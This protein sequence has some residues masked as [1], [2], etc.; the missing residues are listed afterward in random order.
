MM[1]SNFEM[2]QLL[3]IILINIFLLKFFRNISEFI[4]LF[5]YPYEKRKIHKIKVASIGGFLVVF[6]LF[7]YLFLSIFFKSN[8]E[9]NTSILLFGIVFFFLG[10][11]DDKSNLN[12]IIRLA[13]YIIISF[14]LIETNENILVKE[15]KFS[16]FDSVISLGSYS[17]IFTIFCI[18]IFLNAFNMF[19]GINLQSSIYSIFIFSIFAIKNYYLNLS[20][21]IIISLLFFLVLNYKNK[22][23]LGNNGSLFL[24]FLISFIFIESS[25]THLFYS[26]EILL[27]M[28]IPGLDLIR[29]FIERIKKKQNPFSADSNHIHHLLISKFNLIQTNLIIFALIFIPY[30]I[31]LLIG[32]FFLLTILHSFIYLILIL[33]LKKNV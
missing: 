4:N 16:Y 21:I 33:K 14:I 5:D 10:F 2:Y 20:I 19:D 9:I 6:N 29:L 11:L 26:D 24:S 23:F 28:L 15:L 7:I 12:S 13:L 30:F 25:N 3:L 27:I 8:Y 1:Y 17:K 22:C 18:I 31:G 32:N